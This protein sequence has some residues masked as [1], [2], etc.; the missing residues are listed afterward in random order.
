MK[1]TPDILSQVLKSI[2]LEKQLW[3]VPVKRN[4]PGS[5]RKHNLKSMLEEGRKMQ[6]IK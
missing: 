6:F 1:K 5:S 3:L 4:V 2:S